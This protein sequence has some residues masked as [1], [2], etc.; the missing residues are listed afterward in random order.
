MPL[1]RFG[2]IL[3]IVAVSAIAASTAPAR[4]GPVLKI[5]SLAPLTV[6]G[7]GFASRERVAITVRRAAKRIAYRRVFATR[8]GAF[9]TRFS[10]LLVTDTCRGSLIVVASGTSGSRASVSRP[11]RPP[12]PQ[13]P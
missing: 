11:C 4:V 10:P 9:R 7:S 1:A 6:V 12:D 13:T 8:D 2:L 3:L 5:R